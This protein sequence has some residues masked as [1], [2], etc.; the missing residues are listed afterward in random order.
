VTEVAPAAQAHAFTAKQGVLY[1]VIAM[2]VGVVASN[3]GYLVYVGATGRAIADIDDLSLTATA[4]LQVPLWIGFLGVPLWASYTRGR[5]PVEDYRLGVTRRDAVVGVAAGIGTQL[6]L[7]PLLYLPLLELFDV[8]QDRLD[9][10]ARDLTDKA[11]GTLGVVLLVLIVGIG[12]P[13]VEELL[14]R[15]LLQGSLARLLPAPAAIGI[16]ALVFGAFHLQLLQLP[17]LALFGVVAGVLFHRTGR[18]G[19]PILC[20]VAFNLVTVVTLVAG[21]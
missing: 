17:G 12:A 8:D 21:G 15:G 9:D 1:A 11:H 5:G 4:L 13:I 14:Y 3:V 2:I 10:A 19:A 18:L 16:T 7:L 20:H 6:V